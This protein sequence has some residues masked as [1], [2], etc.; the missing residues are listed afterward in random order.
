MMVMPRSKNGC[1]AASLGEPATAI[2]S[3]CSSEANWTKA[4]TPKLSAPASAITRSPEAT[5]TCET[6]AAAGVPGS[7]TLDVIQP[8]RP[9]SR[10]RATAHLAHANPL[11]ARVIGDTVPPML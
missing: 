2:E 3:I 7:A 10:R 6:A 9:S 4:E 11:C 1:K 8:D 5:S